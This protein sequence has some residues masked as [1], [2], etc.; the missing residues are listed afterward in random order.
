MP[1][2]WSERCKK[3]CGRNEREYTVRISSKH[4]SMSGVSYL[5]GSEW[6]GKTFFSTLA[7]ENVMYYYY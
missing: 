6:I 2:S 3:Q 4:M 5:L 7:F 1:F